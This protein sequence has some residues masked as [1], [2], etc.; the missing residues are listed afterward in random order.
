MRDRKASVAAFPYSAASVYDSH[1]AARP[2]TSMSMDSQNMPDGYAKNRVC[3][4]RTG[5]A[6][7]MHHLMHTIR[8]RFS[9]WFRR[10]GRAACAGMRGMRAL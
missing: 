7:G 8:P 6:D 2:P 5:Y 10:F 1:A 9:A 3:I 4:R